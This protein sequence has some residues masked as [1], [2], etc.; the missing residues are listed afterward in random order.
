MF[1]YILLVVFGITTFPHWSV[2]GKILKPWADPGFLESGFTCIMLRG[3]IR[4]D[5]DLS[6]RRHKYVKPFKSNS[7]IKSQY[8]WG[9][10]NTSMNELHLT[11]HVCLNL[12]NINIIIFVKGQIVM[13]NSDM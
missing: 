6:C 12:L 3:S 10:V 13:P 4:I 5:L 7:L 9:S 1:T 11:I 2:S 8:G